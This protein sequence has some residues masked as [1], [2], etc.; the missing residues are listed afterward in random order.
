MSVMPIARARVCA[1]DWR[2]PVSRSYRLSPSA[3]NSVIAAAASGLTASDRR[4][5]ATK[6][7]SMVALLQHMTE[8]DDDRHHLRR[9]APETDMV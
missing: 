2:L 3:R 6:F 1:T 9:V 7:P 5:Q 4:S 8:Y